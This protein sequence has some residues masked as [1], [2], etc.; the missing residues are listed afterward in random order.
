M[1]PSKFT[2]AKRETKKLPNIIVNLWRPP[3][4]AR[5]YSKSWV[6]RRWMLTRSEMLTWMPK[7]L[8]LASSSM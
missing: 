3:I 8:Y 6:T 1:K 5:N 7:N 4:L 2:A